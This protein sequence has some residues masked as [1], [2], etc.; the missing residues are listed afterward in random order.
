MDEPKNHHYVSRCHIK[1]FF[2]TTEKKIYLYDKL[3]DNFYS[4]KS[5]KNIFSEQYLN[6]RF[7]SGEIDNKTLEKDLQVN[8]E[9]HFQRITKLIEDFD[10]SIASYKTETMNALYRLALYGLIGDM[11]NPTHKK[12][13]DDFFKSMYS[14]LRDIAADELAANIQNQLNELDKTKY[15]NELKYFDTALTHLKKMGELD[16]KI[17]I[18]KSNDVFLLPDTSSIYFLAKINEYFNPDILEKAFVGIPLTSKIFVQA[19]SKKLHNTSSEVLKIKGDN[20]KRVALINKD[21]YNQS[22]QTVGTSDESALKKIIANIKG[23]V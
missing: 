6:S 11:R 2:N 12:E 23:I 18:I 20:N 3:Q 7:E 1:N 4:S 22:L 13:N 8:F 21:I 10:V 5:T 9:D 16:F 15:S 14:Y 19:E 17:Y